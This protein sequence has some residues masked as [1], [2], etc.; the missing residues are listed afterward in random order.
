MNGGS[1]PAPASPLHGTA[2]SSRAQLRGP[3][4]MGRNGCD[5]R[6]TSMGRSAFRLSRASPRPIPPPASRRWNLRTSSPSGLVAASR[7]RSGRW[8]SWRRMGSVRSRTK[9]GSRPRSA[10][11][12]CC[13]PTQRQRRRRSTGRSRSDDRPGRSRATNAP[14]SAG[15]QGQ[16]RARK[17]LPQPD[18][19]SAAFLVLEIQ[20]EFPLSAPHT[21]CSRCT[22]MPAT[23]RSLGSAA[24]R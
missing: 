21:T 11:R 1:R 19:G 14:S 2:V 7:S 20:P 12:G 23:T 18:Q 8:C 17:R 13:G 4:P 15:D 6:A 3:S 22:F 10:R 16:P 5:L 9:G 24:G